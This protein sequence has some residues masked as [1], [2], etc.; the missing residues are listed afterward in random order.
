[1]KEFL[2]LLLLFSAALIVSSHAV[3][4]IGDQVPLFSAVSDDETVWGLG[5]HLGKKNVVL[6]FYPAAMTGGCTKQACGYRDHIGEFNS[7][8][9]VVAG[10]S[11][12]DVSSLQVFRKAQNLNFTLLSDP[13][14]AVARLFGVPLSAGGQII[15]NVD[16]MEVI[17]NRGV[18]TQRW[19]FVIG[20]DGTVKYVN[21]Q[22][23]AEND[24][25]AVAKVLGAL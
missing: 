17:L 24:Y 8:D 22:V 16:D 21:Q 3:I 20:K 11:G 9:A 12:D 25:K 23:D 13:E 5:D 7:L 1:M 4:K 6:Y 14:G 10:I 15:R 2:T 19:T 18:T